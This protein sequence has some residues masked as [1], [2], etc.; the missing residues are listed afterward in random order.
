MNEMSIA[1]KVC[2]VLVN[3]NGA[4]HTI[5]C[6]EDLRQSTYP[7]VQAL[8]VDNGS[9]DDS[10]AQIAGRFPD[11]EVIRAG[12]RIAMAEARNRGLRRALA[13]GCEYVLI[14][15]NDTTLDPQLVSHLVNTARA[16]GDLA[17][18]VPKIYWLRDPRRFWF[19]HGRISLWTGIYDNPAHDRIDQGQF[20]VERTVQIASTC[21]VLIPRKIAERVEFDSSLHYSDDVE[22]SLECHRQ[23]FRIVYCPQGKLWH[24]VGGSESKNPPPLLRYLWTRDQLRTLRKHARPLQW[25]SVAFL[26][27]FRAILR[28]IAMIVRRQWGCI[29]AELKGAKEGFFAPIK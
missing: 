2:V 22:W 11:V 28:I 10:P 24:K 4:D 25:A 18:V 3:W 1:P 23:G 5:P 12:S 19:I 8:V 29:P 27:P 15:D 21:C 14:L 7:H 9:S 6:I 13:K 16:Q 20:D 17:A 26:Y